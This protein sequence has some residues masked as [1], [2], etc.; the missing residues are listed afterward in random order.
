MKTKRNGTQTSSFGVTARENHDSSRFYNSK[1]YG[2]IVPPPIT[3]ENENP[4]SSE[5]LN[6]IF[7]KTSEKMEPSARPSV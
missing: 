4:I 6:K 3:L 5:Y 7:C 1:L 2:E